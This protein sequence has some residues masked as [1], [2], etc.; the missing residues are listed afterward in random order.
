MH[1]FSTCD[2]SHILLRKHNLDFRA[3]TLPRCTFFQLVIP[4]TAF[5]GITTLIFVHLP[6]PDALFFNLCFLPQSS[7][8][9]QPWISCIS[10][11]VHRPQHSL[12][13]S[14][15]RF[16]CIRP[17]PMHVFST[18]DSSKLESIKKRCPLPWCTFSNLCFLAPASIIPTSFSGYS[19]RVIKWF[20]LRPI[21]VFP[22]LAQHS[23]NFFTVGYTIVFPA[24]SLLGS[25]NTTAP[26]DAMYFSFWSVH[27]P[28]ANR[29]TWFLK[30]AICFCRTH[31]TGT[32]NL[33]FV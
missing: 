27:I 15:P 31:G 3:S 21:K 19:H 28:Y 10:S 1:D 8:E 12:E 6:Y 22:K 26:N 20:Q 33:P 23:V 16:S 32:V 18:C 30:L 25:G 2:S 24:V 29:P 14:Q 5:W 13:E 9:S 4:P 17:T 7:E 11:L